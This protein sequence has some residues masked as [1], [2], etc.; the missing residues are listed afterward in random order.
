MLDIYYS[1]FH[2]Q[3]F[4]KILFFFQYKKNIYKMLVLIDMLNIHSHK[5]GHF[6]CIQMYALFF[7]LC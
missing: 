2:L 1:H 6:Y 4:Q 7:L 5:N 3:I